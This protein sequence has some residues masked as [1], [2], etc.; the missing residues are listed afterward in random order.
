M[1]KIWHL[2]LQIDTQLVRR[3]LLVLAQ[4][5]R[6]RLARQ[7]LLGEKDQDFLAF[8]RQWISIDI[9]FS[10]SGVTA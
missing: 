4:A 8:A 5:D 2:A 1:D 3:L 6:Y 9:V 10:R 7:K